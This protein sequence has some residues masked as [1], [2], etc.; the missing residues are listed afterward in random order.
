[1]NIPTVSKWELKCA[2]SETGAITAVSVDKC[3]RCIHMRRC[4]NVKLLINGKDA[5]DH[6]WVK[7]R[8]CD[9]H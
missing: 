8:Q 4:L 9:N 5:T 6:L 3:A 7:Q 2:D 1:M